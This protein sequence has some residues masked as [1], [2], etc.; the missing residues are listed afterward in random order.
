MPE[1]GVIVPPTRFPFWLPGHLPTCAWGDQVTF[2]RQHVP[3]PVLPT[4][5]GSHL[6]T[7][8]HAPKKIREIQKEAPSGT[9]CPGLLPLSLWVADGLRPH[10]L[11]GNFGTQVRW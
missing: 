3:D 6:L 1:N 10:R 5:K 4:T 9:E 8:A 11:A 7:C 2:R